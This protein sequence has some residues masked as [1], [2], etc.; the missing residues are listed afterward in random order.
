MNNKHC[1]IIII[2]FLFS[3][4]K[5]QSP[6]NDFLTTDLVF[7]DPAILN[8]SDF[9]DIEQVIPLQTIDQSLIVR[10]SKLDVVNNLLYIFNTNI[11]DPVFKEIMI[12]ENK[13]KFIRKL[14]GSSSGVL[15]F[16][17]ATDFQ[18]GDESLLFLE[19]V[20]KRVIVARDD[21]IEEVISIKTDGGKFMKYNDV[22]W[23][24]R[25]NSYKYSKNIEESTRRSN[26]VIL[27]NTGEILNTLVP[28]PKNIR[29][30]YVNTDRVFNTDATGSSIFFFPPFLDT[31]YH[32]S[33]GGDIKVKYSI[34]NDNSFKLI[35]PDKFNRNESQEII[36]FL[37]DPELCIDKYIVT[38]DDMILVFLR[39]L[40][41]LH[42]IL[43][44]IQNKKSSSYTIHETNLA[45]SLWFWN[46]GYIYMAFNDPL[47][48][49]MLRNLNLDIFKSLDVNSNPIVLKLRIKIDSL[50][51]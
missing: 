23:I 37:N 48:N 33:S 3:C 38:K 51:E 13:G 46:D 11:D 20:L 30:F 9:F 26:L 12:F 49:N 16:R 42:I 39:T 5:Q 22:F 41:K 10:V 4:S 21:K 2:F 36:Q 15:N 27:K 34:K 18:V 6:G 1:S 45:G 8:F 44:N 43:Y 7:K 29:D 32:I 19:G 35:P 47:N 28:I 31:F 25:N 14:N 50:T 40:N 17:Y 24:F